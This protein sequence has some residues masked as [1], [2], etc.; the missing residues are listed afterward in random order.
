M[1]STSSRSSTHTRTRC[2]LM[3]CGTRLVSFFNQLCQFC[4]RLATTFPEKAQDLNQNQVYFQS[5][6]VSK[7]FEIQTHYC[8]MLWMTTII[9]I[10]RPC[11]KSTSLGYSP[12]CYKYFGSHGSTMCVEPSQGYRLFCNVLAST[13]SLTCQ[14]E[15]VVAHLIWMRPKILIMNSKSYDNTCRNN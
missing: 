10:S 13:I 8:I 5:H 3:R 4:G 6:F 7:D 15:W 11:A 14:C 9:R 1:T 2:L 12:S